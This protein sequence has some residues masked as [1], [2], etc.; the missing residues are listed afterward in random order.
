MRV[1]FLT[2]EYPSISHTFIRRE[3]MALRRRGLDVR[4]FSIRRPRSEDWMGSEDRS[5]REGTFYVLPPAIRSL[6]GAHMGAILRGP[7]PYLATL[8]RA[9][10]HRSPGICGCVFAFIYFAEAI[11]LA[12]ALRTQGIT[13][14]HNHFANAAA[15]VGYLAT[16]FLSLGWSLT[17]HG[18]SEFDG[19][20]CMLLQDKLMAA[21]FVACVSHFGRAQAQ[22]Q[23]QPDHWNKLFINRCGIDTSL[24]P[25]TKAQTQR[26]RLRVL[27][28]GRLSPEKAFPGLVEAFAK[29]RAR[30][31]D[32]Q[33]DIIGDG[34]ERE[35]IVSAIKAHGLEADCKLLGHQSEASVFE[36]MANADVFAMSSLMEGLPVVLMEALAMEVPV[37]APC[38]AG[39][40]E[41]VKDGRSGLLYS[42]GYWPDL[43]ECLGKLLQDAELRRRL[44]SEGRRLVLEE[45]DIERAVE[46]I[47]RALQAQH[48]TD[49][50]AAS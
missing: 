2:S 11:L 10:R 27:A 18:I 50:P 40:P 32:A 5:E 29:V 8:V 16:R 34:P 44:G 14:V 7:I 26:A 46:P 15:I 31:I 21:D 28:V 1:A 9:L 24:L 49:R 45:F 48:A 23:I 39:I 25:A 19:L 22:R 33:L 12:R 20:A 36:H 35:V 41:L 13:H 30:G 47:Y 3:V 6:I 38:V 17:L 37:V 4:T 43:G 42:P